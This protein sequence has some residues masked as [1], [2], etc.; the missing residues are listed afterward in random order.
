MNSIRLLLAAA[1]AASAV[2][3]TARLHETSA[4]VSTVEIP[5]NTKVIGMSWEANDVWIFL[6]PMRG[7]EPADRWQ[8]CKLS[9]PAVCAQNVTVQEYRS[10]TESAPVL[11][12]RAGD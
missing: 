10:H 4:R 5:A 12:V 9:T 2:G 7:N 8:L 3:C 11:T 1:A 6:R